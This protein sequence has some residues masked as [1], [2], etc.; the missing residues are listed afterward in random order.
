MADYLTRTRDSSCAPSLS[1]P[2]KAAPFCVCILPPLSRTRNLH[3]LGSH[4]LLGPSDLVRPCSWPW[5]PWPTYCSPSPVNPMAAPQG[6]ITSNGIIQLG[7]VQI[8]S[9]ICFVLF[10]NSF[11]RAVLTFFPGKHKQA[12]HPDRAC[13]SAHLILQVQRLSGWYLRFHGLPLWIVGLETHTLA[14]WLHLRYSARRSAGWKPH[15]HRL[16]A[17]LCGARSTDQRAETPPY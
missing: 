2:P 16:A 8:E 14:G 5:W 11:T 4:G 12:P 3:G 7:L 10:V 17:C 1:S 9:M 13:K 6:P 15:T